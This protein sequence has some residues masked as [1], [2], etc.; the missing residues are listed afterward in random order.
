MEKILF[1]TK[2][3][4]LWNEVH[5]VASKTDIMEHVLQM[6]QI[7]EMYKINYQGCFLMCI[8]VWEHRSFNG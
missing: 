2:N 6:Q 7:S 1:E 5:F 4:K 8:R 3:I